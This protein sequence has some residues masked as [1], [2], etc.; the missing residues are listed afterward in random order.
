MAEPPRDPPGDGDDPARPNNPF[1][2]TPFEQLFSA[3]APGSA[4]AGGTGA[5]DLSLLMSQVQRLMTPYSG[6]VNWPL[7]KDTARGQ[8][9]QQ[10]DPSPTSA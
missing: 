4:G 2:G 1:A 7:A 3:F 8:V 9:A 10:K 6:S 5:P